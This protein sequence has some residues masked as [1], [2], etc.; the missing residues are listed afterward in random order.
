MVIVVVVCV[1][2][3]VCVVRIYRTAMILVSISIGH[4]YF[5][6]IRIGQVCYARISKLPSY[7]TIL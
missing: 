5:D 1:C 7:M 2:V 4:N 6:G 3:Y